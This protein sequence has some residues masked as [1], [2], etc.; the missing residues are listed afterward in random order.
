[1]QVTTGMAPHSTMAPPMAAAKDEQK[2]P[3]QVVERMMRLLDVLEKHP[4]P[5]GLKQ[6]SQYTGL[7]PST[8]SSTASSPAAIASACGFSS[9]GIS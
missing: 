9:S 7:H 3:I 1:M 8:A 6:I 5:L 4:E 2:N